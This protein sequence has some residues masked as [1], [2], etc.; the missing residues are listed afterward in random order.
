MSSFAHRAQHIITIIWWFPM[1]S[2]L[3]TFSALTFDDFPWDHHGALPAHFVHFPKVTFALFQKNTFSI[4][5]LVSRQQEVHAREERFP[6]AFALGIESY[7]L[8]ILKHF[9]SQMRNHFPSSQASHHDP[10][11]AVVP[12]KYCLPLNHDDDDK[13]FPCL[14][15]NFESYPSSA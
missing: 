4:A 9:T 1:I 15:P 14:H 8:R 6:G 5:T 10:H 11:S 3:C 12:P 13:N 7:L 2:S